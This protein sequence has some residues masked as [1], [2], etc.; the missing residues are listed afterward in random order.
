MLAIDE[1]DRVEKRHSIL[2]ERRGTLDRE[3]TE[4]LD[5]L[6]KYDL[7]KR[8]LFWRRLMRSTPTSRGYSESSQGETGSDLVVP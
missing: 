1:Y 5:K 3:R 6:E 2:Q 8:R 7:M 4:I